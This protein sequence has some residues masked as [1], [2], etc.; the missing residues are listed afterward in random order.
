M[1]RIPRSKLEADAG[2]EELVT[3]IL[4]VL[5]RTYAAGQPG[6]YRELAEFF[7]AL[8]DPTLRAIAYRHGVFEEE[9]A[10]EREERPG[11]PAPE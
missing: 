1:T 3:A 11:A 8:D 4:E 7:R 10:E 9:P 6:A 5:D 2:R